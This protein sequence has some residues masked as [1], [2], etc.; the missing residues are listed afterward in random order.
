MGDQPRPAL[1]SREVGNLLAISFDVHRI[2]HCSH[3]VNGCNSRC[4]H[5][6]PFMSCN[7][8]AL[9]EFKILLGKMI[10]HVLVHMSLINICFEQIFNPFYLPTWWKR[11]RIYRTAYFHVSSS[12]RICIRGMTHCSIKP[13]HKQFSNH[14]IK[15][16]YC[17]LSWD[18]LTSENCGLENRSRN[19]SNFDQL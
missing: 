19:Q 10:A 3:T 5:S 2:T 1:T 9:G 14:Q 12:H 18:P 11:W 8:K 13:R 17:C 6:G 4:E 16:H 15:H 7:M